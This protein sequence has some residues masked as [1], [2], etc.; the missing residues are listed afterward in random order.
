[1]TRVFAKTGGVAAN[2][3]AS[4]HEYFQIP[5][6][7][8]FDKMLGYRI[9]RNSSSFERGMTLAFWVRFSSAAGSGQSLLEISN[10]LS[11]EN[12]YVRRIGATAELLF[13]VSHT[14]STVHREY[15]TVN[16]T[17]KFSDEWQHISWIIQPV[18][19]FDAIWNIFIDAGYSASYV[20]VPGVM[21]IDGTYS[22]NFVGFGTPISQSFF[23]GGMDDLRLYERALQLPA[24][25]SIYG[26]EAC[27]QS[28]R[29]A[30]SYIDMTK[31]CTGLD[32]YD[33]R[34]YRG[35]RSDCGPMQ[36]ISNF[37][38]RCDGK[39]DAE[40]T[41]CLPCRSCAAD[42]FVGQVCSGVSLYDEGLCYS[43]R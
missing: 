21:P 39:G 22:T 40:S 20:N 41:T 17:L 19:G 23:T 31:Q 3:N 25:R 13:G 28:G 10:G 43:C 15:S 32:A 37:D 27:C 6:L 12:I 9:V 7:S 35:C 5:R 1:M 34:L 11:T 26:L 30:G 33:P 18:T 38:G 4:N 36:Y 24:I 16:G 14:F 42:Q 8:L 2:F 29:A